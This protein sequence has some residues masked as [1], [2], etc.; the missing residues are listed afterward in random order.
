MKLQYNKIGICRFF[1]FILLGVVLSGCA[2]TEWQP[3][4]LKMA[5]ISWPPAP[6]AKVRYVGEIREFEQTSQSFR[7]LITGKDDPG[8]ILKPVAVAIGPGGKIAIADQARK[9]V[10]LYDPATKRYK[11][12]VLA[13]REKLETPVGVA[14]DD[15]SNIYITDSK[16]GKILIYDSEGTFLKGISKTDK[17]LMQRPTGITFNQ[18]DHRIYVSDTT[19]HQIHVFSRLGQF[20]H[21]MGTRGEKAGSFNFPSHIGSDLKGNIY[22]T[23][24]MN[25]RAQILSPETGSDTWTTFGRHGNGSGDFAS[26]KGIGADSN[27]NI[28]IAETLFDTIQIFSPSGTYLLNVGSQGSGPGQFWMP[29]GLFIDEGNLLYVCDTYNQRIQLFELLTSTPEEP[30]SG[31]IGQ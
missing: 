20:I 3:V 7:T 25:F 4:T 21:S 11:I 29:S 26:P 14:F 13:G 24:S 15:A 30:D 28:F 12:I 31:V 17:G 8:K 22:V 27:G 10:H 23:D 18:H 19:Q 16:L 6:N 9:G 5:E 2:P 1:F